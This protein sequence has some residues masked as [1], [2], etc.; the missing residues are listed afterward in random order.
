MDRNSVNVDETLEAYLSEDEATSIMSMQ[1]LR[2]KLTESMVPSEV[3]PPPE[4]QPA[5][6]DAFKK[7]ANAEKPSSGVRARASFG[8]YLVMDLKRRAAR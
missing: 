6:P 3:P 4:T 1:L 8:Q 2:Q 5:C 7:R